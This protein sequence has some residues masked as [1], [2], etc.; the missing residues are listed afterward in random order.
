[1][2][3]LSDYELVSIS[4]GAIKAKVDLTIRIYPVPPTSSRATGG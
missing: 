1:M 2:R 3:L 4:P